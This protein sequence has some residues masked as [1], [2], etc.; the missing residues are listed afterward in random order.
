MVSAA[1]IAIVAP[2]EMS[3]PPAIRTIVSPKTIGASSDTCRVR[4]SEIAATEEQIADGERKNNEDRRRD[5]ERGMPSADD[6]QCSHEA[7]L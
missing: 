6:Q 7:V 3:I 2:T 1:A 4:F 5:Q